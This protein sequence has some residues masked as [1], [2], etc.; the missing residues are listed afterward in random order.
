MAVTE[1]E[2]FARMAGADFRPQ[3]RFHRWVFPAMGTTNE[4]VFAA[5]SPSRASAFRDAAARWLAAFEARYSVF[6]PGSLVD[7][8]NAAAGGEPVGVTPDDDALFALCDYFYWRTNG[9]LDP[10][11]GPLIELWDFRRRPAAPPPAEAVAEARAR[12]GWPLV[13][14]GAGSIRLPRL[15]MRV[16]LGGFG[17]EFAVDRIAALAESHGIR[18]YL[19]SFGRDIRVRGSA[20]EGGAWRIGLERPDSP[21]GCWNGVA[22]TGGAIACSGDYQRFFEAGNRRYG[23]IIDPRT[24]VPVQNGTRAAWVLAPTCTEAGA[25]ST[26]AVILGPVDGLAAIEAAHHASGCLWTDQ[27]VYQD[28]RFSHYEQKRAA[29]G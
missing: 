4:A 16:D 18:D 25:L 10:T 6:R 27:G 26:A 12:V 5:A 2:F 22:L 11:V 23:H 24:G 19:F 20:P 8:I 17:K 1:Q 9:V 7:R 15:G 13:E 14:R 28:R 29:I 21:E 3:G